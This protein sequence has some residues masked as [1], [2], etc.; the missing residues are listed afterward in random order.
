MHC[1]SCGLLRGIQQQSPGTVVLVR[2]QLSQLLRVFSVVRITRKYRTCVVC[3]Y[4][5]IDNAPLFFRCLNAHRFARPRHIMLD[6]FGSER[7]T[8]PGHFAWNGTPIIDYVQHRCHSLIIGLLQWSLCWLEASCSRCLHSYVLYRPII[9]CKAWFW[10]RKLLPI[11]VN[12][13]LNEWRQT[14]RGR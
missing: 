5:T 14:G 7:R 4:S 6:L 9:M 1:Q 10:S 8:A 3:R 11:L 12:V 13:V 2:Q